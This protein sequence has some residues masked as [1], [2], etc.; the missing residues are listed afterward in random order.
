MA[1]LLAGCRIFIVTSRCEVPMSNRDIVV[2]GGS[3][4]ATSPLKMILG[5]LPAGI[6]AAIFVVMHIPA[7]SLGIL[8]TVASAAARL[9]VHPASDGL[10]IEPGNIYLSVP[11]RHLIVANG[12]I[13]LGK[14]PRENMA[15][16]AIDPLFRSAAAAYGPRVIGVV[17]SGL[18]N[19]GAS[20]LE[21]IKRCGGIALVQDPGDALADE[22]P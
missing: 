16:P 5:A 9:P 17:L 11:D 18:L 6:P 2:I 21:A 20:G 12:R 22:M 10:L 19:D 3:A 13:L 4:G 7:R 8:A 15:R 14:G 1:W